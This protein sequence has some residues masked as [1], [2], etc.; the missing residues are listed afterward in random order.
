[1]A[2]PGP[3]SIGVSS[4]GSSMGKEL[5][6]STSVSSGS[7]W[8]SANSGTTP[9]PS[10]VTIDPSGFDANTDFDGSIQFTSAQAPNQQSLSVHVSIVD[11]SVGCSNGSVIS[12]LP[13][14]AVG[15]GFV[16]DLYVV[17]SGGSPANFSI[18]F[19]NDAGQPLS[20]PVSGMGA[21]STFSSTVT[22]HGPTV[23]ELQTS[24]ATPTVGSARI[25]ADPGITVQTLFRRLGSDNS[26][27]EA[28]VPMTRGG[29]EF[30]VPFDATTFTGNG[31]QIYTGL[32]IANL[33]AGKPANVT[34]TVLD[35]AG[36]QYPNAITIPQLNPLGHW[37]DYNAQGD[38]NFQL[39]G[40]G[41]GTLHC[42]S[43]TTIGA[44]GLRFLGVNAVSSLPI[45]TP[46]GSP[47]GPS[48]V[49]QIAEGGGFVTDL[50]V[51][52]AS[53][54]PANY[55]ISFYDNG[56]Q[57]LTLPVSGMGAL[58]SFSDTVTGHGPKVYEL[59][60]PQAT[61]TAASARI[62]ADP[63]ITV[64]T[65]FRRLGSDNSYYEAAVPMTTGGNEFWIPFDATTF[66]GNGAPIYTGLAIANL[67]AG[68]PA[69]VTCTVLDAAGN[70]YPNVMVPQLNPVGHWADYDAPGNKNF[71]LPGGGVGTL[72]C[73]SDTTIGSMGLRFLGINALSSLPIIGTKGQ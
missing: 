1:M 19:Y 24:Q 10:L 47:S 72:H 61:P 59:G 40:G 44:M 43:N 57:P 27:Y 22:G 37:A 70:Q 25:T 52:N 73:I 45:I 3:Y 66:T 13:Q 32:A 21:L 14:I 58:S 30:W 9:T 8:L 50:Y 62:T 48:V 71:Q 56:G 18:S 11:P 16:T 53:G 33:D 36:K 54:S 17:N 65:L 60:T 68:K 29:N 4:T 12:S 23:Y 31:A 26:Y 67:D 28:A 55:S 34:C 51:V 64:Q 63:G 15:G 38:K 20:I 6:Y 49:P 35:A 7:G 69:N 2:A 41:V 39:P 5:M 46:S 42:I